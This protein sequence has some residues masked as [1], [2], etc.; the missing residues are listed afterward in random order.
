VNETRT[1]DGRADSACRLLERLWDAGQRPDVTELLAEAGIVDAARAARVLALD[2]WRRWHSGQRVPAEDYLARF[3][4]VAA[5]PEA[6]LELI[7]GEMLVREE[8]GEHPAA[9]EYLARFPLWA[10]GLRQQLQIHQHLDAGVANTVPS[11]EHS[12]HPTQRTEPLDAAPPIPGLPAIPGYEIVELL[13]R[14][15][16]GVVYKA[17]HLGLKRLVALKMILD[18]PGARTEELRRF[19]IEAEAVARLQHPNIVQIYEVGEWQADGLGP[20]LPYLAL[21]FVDGG[22]L[23]ERLAKGPLEAH[24]AAELVETLA[25]AMH[26]AH[27]RGIVHRDLKPANVLLHRRDKETGRQGDKEKAPFSLSPCLPV[28]LSPKITDFGLAKF[29]DTESGQTRTGDVLG[30]PRYMAPEQAQGWV[31]EVG[32]VTDVYALGAILYHALTGKSP[33]HGA[34]A[35]EIVLQVIQQEPVPPTQLQPRLPRDLETICLKCLKKEGGQRYGSA[36]ELA[37][38]LRRF[39]Q[40]EPIH[41]RPVGVWERAAKWV[42]RRPALASAVLVS[43]LVVIGSISGSFIHLNIALEQARKDWQTETDRAQ[44]LERRSE[45][46]NLVLSAE[47]AAHARDWQGAELQA[48]EALRRIGNVEDESPLRQR[49]T[50]VHSQ[51]RL[52]LDDQAHLAQFKKHRHEALSGWGLLFGGASPADLENVQLAA[53]ASLAEFQVDPEAGNALVLSTTY[54]PAEKTAIVTGCYELLLVLAD[55]SASPRAGQKREDTSQQT[56]QAVRILQRA[57]RLGVVT[58]AYHRRLA[59]YRKQLGDEAGARRAEDQAAEVPPAGALDYF[60]TGQERYQS[61]QLEPARTDFERAWLIQPDHFWARYF[62]ALCQL[63]LHQPDAAVAGFTACLGQGREDFVWLYVLRALAHTERGDLVAAEADFNAA[64]RLHPDKDARYGIHTNRASLRLRQGRP[65][66]AIAELRA[67]VPLMPDHHQAYMN[68]AQIYRSQKNWTAAA[69]QLELAI[70][71]APRQ[72]ELY[73]ARAQLAVQRGESDKAL[74]DFN[75][76]IKYETGNPGARA[77]DH[78]EIARLHQRAR[79]YED[80]RKEFEAAL[81]EQPDQGEALRGQGESLLELKRYQEAVEA[82]EHYLKVGTA[83]AEVYSQLGLARTK[84]GDH[85][86]A[87]DDYSEALRMEP[88]AALYARHGWHYLMTDSFRLAR[89]DFDQAIN[90]GPATGDMYAGR[91]FALVQ[92]SETKPALEDA[93][94]AVQLGPETPELMPVFLCNV[95]RIYSQALA[96]LDGT[97]KGHG[98]ELW[99]DCQQEAIR[100]IKRALDSLPSDERPGFWKDNIHQGNVFKPL[101]DSSKEFRDLEKAQALKLP[102]TPLT[103]PQR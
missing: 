45:T 3:P 18:Q 81:R 97:S 33:F 85:W 16:M 47:A 75:L 34:T 93:R 74:A 32:P 21:E 44:H 27:L 87:L 17:R 89:R 99:L 26:V 63:R 6:A 2:Q 8:L 67:A 91:G 36:L 35:L 11:P 43:L 37:D 103:S 22:T 7:Y 60:L 59:H 80:A 58:Q 56:N 49:A 13:G 95:A 38:D 77:G 62:H 5:A 50:G 65:E 14:G 15:G 76:A 86:R 42:R 101:H 68:L 52:H 78:L 79:K 28:S 10:E 64:L 73:R 100:L 61:G 9:E 53:R 48:A 41:A 54:S 66:D 102:Q 70:A 72:A 4:H 82:F 25:R 29:L 90:L 20:A 51:A 55:S 57:A 84:M 96:R 23:A 24:A 94:K 12:D 30:T 19:R 39:L 40:N 88:T 46:Q 69:E 92:L 98:R 1:L 31:R 71:K 83:S